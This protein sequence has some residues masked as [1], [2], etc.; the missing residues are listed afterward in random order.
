[1][2]RAIS[3]AGILRIFNDAGILDASDIHPAAIAA[4]LGKETDERVILACALALRTLRSGS[5]CLDIHEAERARWGDGSD[6]EQQLPWPEPKLWHQ[7]LRDSTLTCDASNTSSS[8]IPFVLDEGLLYTQKAWQQQ[9]SVRNALLARHAASPPL[10]DEAA[11]QSMQ[12]TGF[13]GIC[14]QP[15]QS[16]AIENAVRGLTSVIAGGPG[17]GKTTVIGAI[18]RALASQPEVS[19]VALAAPT[20]RAAA[21]MAELLRDDSH[22]LDISV[23]TLHKLLGSRGPNRGFA[24]SAHNPLPYSCIIV[25]EMSMVSLDMMA[26]LL[27]ALSPS[28]RL[29][30]VGDPDQLASVEAGSVLA[31]IV[32]ADL[33]LSPTQPT[34]MVTRLDRS[35]RF[36]GQLAD[37]A[38][39]VRLGDADRALD[40]LTSAGAP[41]S[42]DDDGC[43]TLASRSPSSWVRSQDWQHEHRA[44]AV[45]VACD[46]A[47]ATET[48]LERVFCAVTQQARNLR[49]LAVAADA[50]GALTE[51]STHRLLCAHRDGP[52]GVSTWQRRVEG[53]LRAHIPEYGKGEWYPGRPLLMTNNQPALELSNGDQGVVALIDGSPQA[54][55]AAPDGYRSIP[56]S[57]LSHVPSAHAITIHKSQGSQ[58]RA[59]SVILPD[60]SVLLTRELLYTA[61]TRA[62]ERLTIVGTKDALRRAIETPA[63][64]ASGLG[65]RLKSASTAQTLD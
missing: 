64:R 41:A 50:A 21:R 52:Y 15:R 33:A 46:P 16:A 36:D 48:E 22:G 9:E 32:A 55:F 59:I 61:I 45:L 31:D 20:G 42:T 26:A 47:H 37:L 25:D 10:V 62:Q 51:L 60:E 7:L 12:D 53:H 11:L 19:R 58:S 23:A 39:A 13:D 57:L 40:L 44:A 30:L 43:A 63:L 6:A 29:V 38:D 35:F 54:C 34:P 14:V 3:A 28:T 56:P 8:G 17:T 18:L 4:R 49:R 27:E 24:H 1:M 5:V 65:A 2:S